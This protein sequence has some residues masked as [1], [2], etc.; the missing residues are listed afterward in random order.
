MSY[1]LNNSKNPYNL[2]KED[3][4]DVLSIEYEDQLNNYIDSNDDDDNTLN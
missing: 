1:L 2:S 3:N 4:S